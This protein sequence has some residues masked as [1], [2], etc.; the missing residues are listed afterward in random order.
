MQVGKKNVTEYFFNKS[1]QILFFG[2]KELQ[3]RLLF[4]PIH[5]VRG[6]IRLINL[7]W[8]SL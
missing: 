6:T 1:I 7:F 5:S 3:N 2:P 8:K 4:F